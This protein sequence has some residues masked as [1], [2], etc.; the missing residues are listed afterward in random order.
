MRF[1]LYLWVSLPQFHGYWKQTWDSRSETKTV[2][3]SHNSTSRSI[4]VGFLSPTRRHK[5][6]QIIPVNTGGCVTGEESWA[7]GSWIFYEQVCFFL[8]REIF[9][10]YWIVSMPCSGGRYCLY[11]P[12]HLLNKHPWKNS[13]KQRA[14][15]ALLWQTCRNAREW[16][17]IVFQQ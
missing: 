3:Y 10:L 16:R 9:P 11:F 1:S 8:Q 17:R 13:V 15:S 2:Y 7:Q 14:V 12:R 5:K 4:S 6:G